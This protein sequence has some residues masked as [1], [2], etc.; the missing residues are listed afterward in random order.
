MRLSSLTRRTSTWL[1]TLE[2]SAA[3]ERQL[4]QLLL[5]YGVVLTA[6]AIFALGSRHLHHDMT[7]V[8]AWG[9]EFQLG[10]AKHPPLSAWIAGLWFTV[11]PRTS[12][13]F[14]L[15]SSLNI[16]VALSGVWMLAGVFVGT[17]GRLAAILFLVLTPS[18]SFWALKFNVNAP[19]ISTWP[20]TTYFFLRS[21]ET[22]RI[23]FSISAGILGG[24]AML[25]KYSSLVLFSTLFLVALLRP[26]RRQYFASAAPY[27]TNAIGVA[28]VAPHVWWMV[29]SGF[30]TIDYAISTTHYAVA[31]ARASAI[32]A[33]ASG[34]ASLGVAIAAYA[35]AFGSQSR[36]LLRRVVAGTF[37]KRNAWLTCLAYGPLLLTVAA[38]LLANARITANY[39]IPVFFATP[40]VLLV[41]SQADFTVVVLRRLA[42]CV[43]AIWLPILIASP[44]VGYY[45][46]TRARPI[47]E[48]AVEA[49][50]LWRST[51]ERPLRYVSGKQQIATGTAFHSPDG[52]SYLILEQPFRSP[53]V[54]IEQAR[55]KGLLI[56]CPAAD[57]HC[58][59]SGATLAGG[60]SNRHARELATHFFGRTGP[61]QRFVFIIRPPED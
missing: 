15:L 22:R 4:L 45:T 60:E 32:S 54:T 51:F 56:I 39:L 59:K 35:I 49:T 6:F 34:A 14:Y 53:W 26:D 46:F 24:I 1:R 41:V 5:V 33:V 7:E 43:A 3:P 8:W 16:A 2:S 44:L 23:D 47:Q 27:V 58:I 37:E 38:Y 12:W 61:P 50:A 13:S 18:F 30:P 10:Y 55:R 29:A 40:I 42:F 28:V 21:L 31:E 25:T 19:L 48:I 11:M 36:L 9:K 57:E 17:L 52:P 20:W